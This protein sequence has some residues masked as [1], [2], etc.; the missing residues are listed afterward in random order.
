MQQILYYET[1]YF[2]IEHCQNC[3]IPGYFIIYAKDEVYSIADLTAEAQQALGQT[4]GQ[5]QQLVRNIIKPERIYT[6]SFCEI[7]PRL[8]LHIFPRTVEML[9]SY[10]LHHPNAPE[11]ANG[12]LLFEW[13]RQYYQEK[14]LG[15]YQQQMIV[16][17][18]ELP[19]L[20]STL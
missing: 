2:R 7:L 18:K 1:P 10:R 5:I 4:L 19:Q 9:E 13:A 8:H 6:L 15:D 17:A 12:A 3:Q 14:P 16:L 11:E 20:D